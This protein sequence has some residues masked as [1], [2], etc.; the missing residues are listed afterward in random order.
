[1]KFIL[2]IL[3]FLSSCVFRPYETTP[4]EKDNTAD[5]QYVKAVLE[6]SLL[7]GHCSIADFPLPA[8]KNIT[9]VKVRYELKA[10]GMIRWFIC[11]G[12]LNDTARTHR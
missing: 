7:S 4:V 5:I 3:I 12:K 10:L 2:P 1:M 9:L 11:K 8:E 6:K